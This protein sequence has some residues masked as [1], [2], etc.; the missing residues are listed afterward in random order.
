KLAVKEVLRIAGASVNDITDIAIARD[1]AANMAAKIA[2]VAKN[3]VS[4]IPQALNRLKAHKEAASAAEEI[5][6]ALEVDRASVRADMHNVEHHLAHVAS[7]YF[8]SP[9]DR[10]TGISVD[11]AGDFASSMIAR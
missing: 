7:A 5:A 3:V 2:F 6:D 4:A 8:W 1:P 10:A 9:L 11:G